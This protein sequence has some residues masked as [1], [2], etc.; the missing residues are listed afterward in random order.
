ML[1]KLNYTG[2][3]SITKVSKGKKLSTKFY[4]NGTDLLFKAYAMALQGQDISYL[5]PAYVD[6]KSGGETGTS[7]LNS[8]GV[9]VVRSV[10]LEEESNP[11]NI[12]VGT[13]VPC[14]RISATL[15]AANISDGGGSQNLCL[16][17]ETKSR[18]LLA[19]TFIDSSII[20]ITTGTQLFIVWDLYISN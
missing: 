10:L 2:N 1:D 18:G 14:T 17:L 8:S 4:N 16:T 3:V 13:E 12:T 15:T 6:I 7:I 9:S 19:Y 20:D 5:L 11:D